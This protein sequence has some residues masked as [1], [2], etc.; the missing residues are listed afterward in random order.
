MGVLSL[1]L[2]WHMVKSLTAFSLEP[3]LS[4]VVHGNVSTSAVSQRLC[5]LQGIVVACK[6]G[7]VNLR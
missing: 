5:A 2:T 3:S 1:P 6:L 4:S 7:V